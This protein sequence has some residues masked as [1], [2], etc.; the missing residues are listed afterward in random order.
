M[1]EEVDSLRPGN[2]G[3]GVG[4]HRLQGNVDTNPLYSF[5]YLYLYIRRPFESGRVKHLAFLQIFKSSFLLFL[6]SFLPKLLPLRGGVTSPLTPSCSLARK[7]IFYPNVLGTYFPDA[8]FRIT[9][10]YFLATQ[11]FKSKSQKAPKWLPKSIP[12]RNE[13]NNNIMNM[14]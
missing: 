2:P 7:S 5:T 3:Q 1:W 10:Y 9:F 8:N 12:Q 14:S 11:S 6:P 4:G 13:N